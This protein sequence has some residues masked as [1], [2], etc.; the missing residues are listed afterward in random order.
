LAREFAKR[1]IKIGNRVALGSDVAIGNRVAIGDY[2]T[3]GYGV[4]IGDYVAIGN[5]VK[6]G[7][8]VAIGNFVKIG[9]DVMIGNFVKIGNDVVIPKAANIQ[10]Q[11]DLVTINNLGSRNAPL[12]AVK[13]KDIVHVATG[14]FSGSIDEFAKKVK[15]VHGESEHGM[16]YLD[17]IEHIRKHFAR[18]ISI[19]SH[20]E[21]G[22]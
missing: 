21:K 18:A 2:V 9:N 6:I 20:D 5:F 10:L 17:A 1:N 15:E 11:Y 12:S 8:D 14:C 16:R 7:D 4:T 19:K 13:I 22:V 3:I